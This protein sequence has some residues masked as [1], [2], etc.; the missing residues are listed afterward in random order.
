MSKPPLECSKAYT[1]YIEPQTKKKLLNFA[2]SFKSK[3]NDL[4]YCYMLN[5]YA[6]FHLSSK[7]QALVI[8][9][10][11]LYCIKWKQTYIMSSASVCPDRH[12]DRHAGVR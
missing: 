5:E 7:C 6:E 10:G 9:P 4:V 12:T 3:N 11:S 1:M 2:K 8:L